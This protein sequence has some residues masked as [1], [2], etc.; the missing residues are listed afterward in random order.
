VSSRLLRLAEAAGD[1][2]CDARGAFSAWSSSSFAVAA[3][4]SASF[5][6]PE[7][8]LLAASKGLWLPWPGVAERRLLCWGDASLKL[9]LRDSG[10]RL[11]L[12]LDVLVLPPA[13]SAGLKP[14]LA[15]GVFDAL[16][17]VAARA[18]SPPSLAASSSLLFSGISGIL[19]SSRTCSSS[20]AAS[21]SFLSALLLGPSSAGVFAFSAGVTPGTKPTSRCCAC[22]SQSCIAPAEFNSGAATGAGCAAACAAGSAAGCN[23]TWPLLEGDAP[24]EAGGVETV[25]ACSCACFGE[26][27]APRLGADSMLC[28][29]TG[30]I[31]M[32]L[33]TAD[34][35]ECRMRGPPS[36]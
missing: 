19:G 23:G 24:S 35:S 16:Q 31:A 8:D 20:L 30:A 5:A 21:S 22:A 10:V 13:Q 28:P 11:R 2:S 3:V 7:T 27:R 17:G 25:T 32:P 29:A 9:W 1:A 36:D 15:L 34:L 33:S 4:A 6:S 26:T 12:L 14:P 18:G